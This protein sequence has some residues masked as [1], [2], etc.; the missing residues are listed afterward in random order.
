MNRRKQMT[1]RPNVMRRNLELA[2]RLAEENGGLLPHPWKMIEMGH[3]GLYRYILR[4]PQ[5]FDHFGVE[6]PPSKIAG[7]NASIREKHLKTARRLKTGR[8]G[9]GRGK[10]PSVQWLTTH[11]YSK[12]VAYMKNYPKVFEEI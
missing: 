9:E 3:G 7:Y 11:G 5:E 12:L 4:H 2:D 10:M 1:P 8:Y 6:E